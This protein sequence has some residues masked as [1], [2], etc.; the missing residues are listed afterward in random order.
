MNIV[1]NMG[2]TDRYLRFGIAGILVALGWMT[3]NLLLS[4]IALV[5]VITA[6]IG[7]CPAY[8][9]LKIN[10]NKGSNPDDSGNGA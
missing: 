4:L 7:F 1:K 2:L 8:V 3:N 9:P 6:F 5:P 10:T